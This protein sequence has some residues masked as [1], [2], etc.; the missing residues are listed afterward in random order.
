MAR[1]TLD[2]AEW[3]SAA[4]YP[5]RVHP[6]HLPNGDDHPLAG[7]ATSWSGQPRRTTTGLAAAVAAGFE[8]G[9]TDPRHAQHFNEWLHQLWSWLNHLRLEYEAAL[10][11]DF[12]ALDA[13]GAAVALRPFL[14]RTAIALLGEPRDDE[15]L[16]AGPGTGQMDGSGFSSIQS[17]IPHVSYDGGSGEY[18]LSGDLILSVLDMQ[19]ASV[20]N[21][22]GYRLIVT[23][24]L[25]M[26]NGSRI[27]S[28]SP[29]VGGTAVGTLGGHGAGAS[30]S[31]SDTSALDGDD[32]TDS[33]GGNGG[34][35]GEG[36][37]GAGGTA[38]APSGTTGVMSTLP[39]LLAGRTI[40]GSVIRGGAGG[41]A[42]LSR[43][44]GAGGGGSGGHGGGVLVVAAARISVSSGIATI[45][46]NGADGGDAT[47]GGVEQQGG[48]GGGGGGVAIRIARAVDGAG[49][50]VVEAN[51]G[52]GGSG[53]GG[54]DAGTDG[55]DGRVIE[56]D[57]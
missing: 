27:Y 38:T 36:V 43:I 39:E 50:L 53:A 9:N 3:A 6:T 23:E 56:I 16:G 57:L 2:P 45:E 49:T 7:L 20:L 12:D 8:P 48:G 19:S 10:D 44:D 51:G 18:R 46:A 11:Q 28:R 24:R 13:D 47:F 55:G 32:V 1:P 42:G 29:F 30:T 14:A 15:L 54:G 37:N 21:L 35:G 31:A 22:Q 17:D 40:D 25:I 52:S 34:D 4:N 33:L 26:S 41:G 5:A